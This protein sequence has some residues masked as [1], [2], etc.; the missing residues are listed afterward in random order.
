MKSPKAQKV[1]DS[2]KMKQTN[3]T[4]LC[5]N[6]LEKQKTG[7]KIRFPVDDKMEISLKLHQIV[8]NFEYA[9]WTS[10]L[11]VLY[12]RLREKVRG[13]RSGTSQASET[14]K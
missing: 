10:R 12:P 1:L 9:Q 6:K 3:Q 7:K 13:L 2:E 11:F 14:G 8:Q 4:K 5:M